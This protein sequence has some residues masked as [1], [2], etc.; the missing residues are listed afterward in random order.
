[1]TFQ[2]R[3]HRL[4]TRLRLSKR[5]ISDERAV[6]NAAYGLELM[7]R[8]RAKISQT[9]APGNAFLGLAG[10]EYWPEYSLAK[11]AIA[12]TISCVFRRWPSEF[13]LQCDAG[14]GAVHPIAELDWQI[15]AGLFNGQFVAFC[16]TI[17]R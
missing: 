16:A 1:M 8:L 4:C 11:L 2:P 13:G 9:G 5:E 7:R 14:L 17:A 12:R 10:V 3:N 15:D 6:E